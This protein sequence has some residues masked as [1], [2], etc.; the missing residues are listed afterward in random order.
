LL[1]CAKIEKKFFS[2]LYYDKTYWS[3]QGIP[4]PKPSILVGNLKDFK[5]GRHKF[6]LKC[7]EKYGHTYGYFYELF[8]NFLICRSYFMGKA[9]L[10]SSDLDIL[11]HIL[12]KDFDHFQDRNVISKIL[13]SKKKLNFFRCL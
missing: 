11:R 10:A 9:D 4:G 6:D 13:S 2:Y 5:E 8:F 7:K 12:V 3:R 1:Q